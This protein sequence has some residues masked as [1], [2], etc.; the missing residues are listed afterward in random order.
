MAIQGQKHI[1]IGAENV[2]A[3]S[4]TLH[5]AFVK[6]EDNFNNLFTNSSQYTTF[7]AGEGVTVLQNSTV[8]RVTVTN[9]GVVNLIE[10]TGIKLSG[11]NGEVTV[12]VAGDSTGNLVAGV[13]KIGIISSTLDIINT[14]IISEGNIAVNLSEIPTILEGEYKTPTMTIDK[15]GRITQIANTTTSGTVTSV[16][17]TAGPG[18]AVTGS[19]ITDNGEII[20]NNTGVLRLSAGP[21]IQLTDTTGNITISSTV[22]PVGGTVT[23]VGVLSNT[24][25]VTQSPVTTSGN[26]VIE[27]PDAITLS[28]NIV[29]ANANFTGNAQVSGD[30]MVDGD[31]T[32]I[33]VST[34]NITSSASITATGNVSGGNI[35]TAGII[36]VTG[37]ATVGNIIANIANITTAKVS[38]NANIG[39]ANVSGLITVGGNITGGNLN[40]T[41]TLVA[42]TANVGNV[43]VTSNVATANLNT[44]IAT[45]NYFILERST[46]PTGTIPDGTIAVD[47]ANSRIGVRINGAWK[48]ATLS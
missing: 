17:V 32:L 19:P 15:Y 12:S 13:T 46:L 21:G 24:M 43:T 31:T 45:A 11:A 9:T 7:T 16:A 26:I 3:D 22:V 37:N 27:L 42:G 34:S 41:G 18:L 44:N 48:Y 1:R 39:N 29:A 25:V 6:I 28:G 5:T 10:G 30:L 35:S 47:A 14:P 38:G 2:S 33:D 20:I 36:T 23:R 4:D 8:G 40:T